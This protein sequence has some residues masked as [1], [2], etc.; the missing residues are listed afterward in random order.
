M[1][2]GCVFSLNLRRCTQ[3]VVAAVILNVAAQ[4][5]QFQFGALVQAGI[6]GAGDWELGVGTTAA[7]AVNTASLTN[8]WVAGADRMLQLEYLKPTNTVNVR[9]YDG[10]TATGA[11]TQVSYSPAGGALVGANAIWTLPAASFFA[12]ASNGP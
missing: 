11:F 2:S 6:A 1:K 7:A 3:V 5:A 9:L 10:A 8:Q 4:G 12:T